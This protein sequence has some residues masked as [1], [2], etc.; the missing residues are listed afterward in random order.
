MGRSEW[1]EVR[2]RG[3]RGMDVRVRECRSGR[4]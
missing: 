4:E 3:G 2:E 1:Y